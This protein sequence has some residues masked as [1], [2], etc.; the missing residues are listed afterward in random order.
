MHH[1]HVLKCLNSWSI[2]KRGVFAN[3]VQTKLN[4]YY[5]ST[6][7][8]HATLNMTVLQAYIMNGTQ[9]FEFLV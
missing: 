3:H 5:P 9:V 8:K 7:L 6:Y 4:T 1:T 2:A